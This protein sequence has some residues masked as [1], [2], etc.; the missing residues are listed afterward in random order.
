MIDI[1]ASHSQRLSVSVDELQRLNI[2]TPDLKWGTSGVYV[3]YQDS[4]RNIKRKIN[5]DSNK[6]EVVFPGRLWCDGG[7]SDFEVMEGENYIVLLKYHKASF[8]HVRFM[9]LCTVY[10]K[11]I[12]GRGYS[13]L[14]LIR[15]IQ[16]KIIY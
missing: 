6:E 14:L 5:T 11:W 8:N 10:T 2:R 9:D 15:L 7:Y 4:K 13:F 1:A 12:D 3:Y 16:I